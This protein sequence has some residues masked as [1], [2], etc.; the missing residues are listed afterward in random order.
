MNIEYTA[1]C[2][3]YQNYSLNLFTNML[4][5]ITINNSPNP[6]ITWILKLS[7]RFVCFKFP[8]IRLQIECVYTVHTTD[9]HIAENCFTLS[10]LPEFGNCSKLIQRKTHLLFFVSHMNTEY[11]VPLNVSLILKWKSHHIWDFNIII[12]CC[13]CDTPD[14]ES[15]FIN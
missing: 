2:C 14:F 5:L 15:K 6:E 13:K 4:I 10:I 7:E 12:L 11:R 8:E 1:L 9:N 3:S